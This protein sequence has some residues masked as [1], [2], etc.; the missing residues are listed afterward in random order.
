MRKKNPI[1]Y[2]ESE[3]RRVG[4]AM[5]DFLPPLDQLVLHH[6]YGINWSVLKMFAV[7]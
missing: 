3:I 4:P 1:K 7:R 2:T 6:L 5:K